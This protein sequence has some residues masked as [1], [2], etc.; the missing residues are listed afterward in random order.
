MNEYNSLDFTLRSED[1]FY[2][3]ADLDSFK[4]QDA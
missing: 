1:V 4:D 3:A 2:E